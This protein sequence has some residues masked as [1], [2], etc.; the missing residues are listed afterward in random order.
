VPASES[1]LLP[2]ITTISGLLASL[3]GIVSAI[4]SIR[5]TRR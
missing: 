3:A 5:G 2:I 4:V 1:G